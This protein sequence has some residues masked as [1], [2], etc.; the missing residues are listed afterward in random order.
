MTDKDNQ[1]KPEDIE[2]DIHQSRERLDSTLHEIEERFSPQQ[3]LNTSYEYIRQGVLTNLL[4]T[5]A[6]RLSKTH[7][8]FCSPARVLA[9]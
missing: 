9:G 3:L 7:C 2:K 8:R 1:R 6:R 4:P 5:W